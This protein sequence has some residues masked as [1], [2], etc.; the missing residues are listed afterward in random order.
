MAFHF[1]VGNDKRVR[2]SIFSRTFIWCRFGVTE[3]SV[4]EYPA[5]LT[6]DSAKHV[7]LSLEE[8]ISG[9][10]SDDA[11]GTIKALHLAVGASM[12]AAAGEATTKQAPVT[13]AG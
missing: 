9:A 11:A 4:I 7:F 2:S 5:A 13:T 12:S 10:G 8:L 6:K 1:I 3:D